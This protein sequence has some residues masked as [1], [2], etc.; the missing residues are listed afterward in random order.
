MSAAGRPGALVAFRAGRGYELGVVVA[1]AK[2]RLLL[3]VEGGREER[4]QPARVGWAIE[5]SG[6]VPGNTPEARRAAGERVARAR[7]GIELRAAGLDVRTLWEIV[8]ENGGEFELPDLADLAFDSTSGEALSAVWSALEAEA[9]HFA[10][11]GERFEARSAPQVDELSAE[12]RRIV[13]RDRNTEAFFDALRRVVKGEA[14]TPAGGE[15]GARYLDALEQLAL[16]EDAVD[17]AWRASAFEALEASGLRFDR[18]HEGAFRLLRLAGRFAHDDENLQL[19]R[20]GLSVE[21]PALVV[22]R[23]RELTSRP[24]DRSGRED[25]TALDSLSIDSASTREIDD[26]LS[27]V[28]LDGMA[29]R[30]FV[31]IA[32]PGAFV[33]P[34]DVVDEEA[35][36]RGLTHYHPDVRLTMLPAAIGE[37][38]A[39]LTLDAERPALSFIVDLAADGSLLD[40]R[41]ARTVVRC[42]LRLDYAAVDAALDA[43]TGPHTGLLRAL[44]TVAEAREGKRAADGAVLIRTPDV[45]VKVDADGRVRLE[46][47]AAVSVARTIVTES[48]VLAGA[49]AARFCIER[50]LPAIYRRQAPPAGSVTIPTAGVSDPV[51]VRRIR[52]SMQ[53]AESGLQPGRHAGLGL[54]AYAQ[55]TSPLRRF[56]DLATLRQIASALTGVAPVYDAHALQRIAATTDR[57]EADARRGERAA[58]DYWMLR[59]FEE[60][61]GETFEALVVEAEP[62]VV[63]QIEGTSRE[64]PMP[65]LAGSATGE[66]VAVRVERVNAR[67]GLLALRRAD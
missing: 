6:P 40:W 57:A 9:L 48:M 51:E 29:S 36:R 50:A 37:E 15:H 21:F 67:A 25:L 4:I 46:R 30:L 56:Q 23:A 63:V 3:V 27:I 41:I 32:D 13:E 12:R 44:A 28:S 35:L 18:P 62:R 38:A 55:A 54:E 60:R 8:G 5:S 17:P 22:E 59:W 45:D 24:F 7:E 14:F 26:A 10:R 49:L 39:S 43:G 34:G 65:A 1:E 16:H 61:I 64:Q 52:R 2:G 58:N 66:R 19:R 31:H 42:N 47:L 11:R 20:F 53:R 33:E